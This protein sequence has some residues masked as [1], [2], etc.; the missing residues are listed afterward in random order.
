MSQDTVT[1]P[2][3]V[4]GPVPHDLR[5]PRVCF[6]AHNGYGALAEVDDGHA[7]G[8]ERQLAMMARWTASQGIPTAMITWDNGNPDGA[9]V[10]GVE[11]FNLCKRDAGLPLVRFVYPRWFSLNAALRR[12]DADVY[13][14]NKGD[15]GL[16][17]VV[18]WC[19]RAG[20]RCVY[21]VA[22]TPD[23][24]PRLPALPPM[25]EK[26][27]YRYGLRRVD[28]I[29]CQTREQQRMLVDGFGRT[30]LTLPMPCD[31]P[32]GQAGRTLPASPRVLWVGRFRI[33]KRLEWLLDLA[34]RFPQVVFDVVGGMNRGADYQR[35]AADVAARAERTAN[36]VLHGRVTP[37]QLR[38]LYRDAALLC[39]TSIYEGFPNT[40]LE[41]W[42]Q[43]TPTLSTYDPDGILEREG[44]G[45][46]V[47]SVDG[48]AEVLRRVLE[49]PAEWGDASAR[50]HRYY[51]DNHLLD[52]CMQRFVAIF[53]ELDESSD[54]N[55]DT[56]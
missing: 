35:Y 2:V 6:I 50:A 43:G 4:A 33:E 56:R 11:V 5:V 19:R 29:V 54:K 49:N 55:R 8:V 44:A 46:L 51:V 1:S 34:D 38:P 21:S 25:R 10:N 42:S 20:K 45:W 16:G 52:A 41:G 14:Y 24:D 47:R 13:Y 53:R 15:G 40:F 32:P 12:A 48:L 37:E 39:C 27:L 30:S 17:Q 3:A 36:V 31:Y 28:Q 9:P 22:S 23:C 18:A 26:I 7:G